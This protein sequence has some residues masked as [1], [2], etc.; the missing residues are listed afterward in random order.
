MTELEWLSGWYCRPMY[1][2]VRKQA[3]TRQVRLYMAACCRL[4]EAEFF[5]PRILLAVEAAE[6]CA[7]DPHVER[8]A[9]A[10]GFKFATS[11]HPKLPQTGRDGELARVIKGANQLLDNWRDWNGV[12]HR[13][14]RHAIAH[15]AFMSLRDKPQEVFTGGAGDAAEYCTQMI[16][17]AATLL[18]GGT[19]E[20]LE[21]Y[22][23]ELESQ[24]RRAIAGILRDI[25]GNPFRPVAIDSSWLTSS[26]TGLAQTIY[27][28][29]AFNHL[30]ILADALEDAGCTNADIL[31]HCRQPG[32]HARG[33][34]A[35]DLILGKE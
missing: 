5:D 28:E 34:W 1:Q 7:D 18:L 12:Q 11:P 21:L 31:N 32:D 3:T 15:A 13:D 16:V 35:L 25:F 26:V 24:T 2:V 4:L 6:C 20:G 23:P 22:G 8:V 27:G 29:R 30:P 10:V 19:A 33:C 14:A 17:D 9:N